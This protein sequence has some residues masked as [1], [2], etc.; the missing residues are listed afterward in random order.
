MGMSTYRNGLILR[1]PFS[2]KNRNSDGFNVK[3]HDFCLNK[4]LEGVKL[5]FSCLI[6]ELSETD[7]RVL[8]FSIDNASVE[9]LLSAI[10]S[11][12]VRIAFYIKSKKHLTSDIKE[13]CNSAI[14]EIKTCADFVIKLGL[15][16]QESPIIIHVGG[17]KGDRRNSMEKFCDIIENMLPD[18]IKYLAVIN[19]DKPSLFSVKDLLPGV[20]YRLRLPI[21]FR[22]MS[23]PTNQGNLTLN[24]SLFLAASTWKREHNPIFVY[25]PDKTPLKEGQKRPF[26]LELDIVFDNRLPEP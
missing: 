23:Y 19:D 3:F 21:V 25:L 5:G 1:F 2:P 17:A 10:E 6:F 7:F 14:E 18:Y 15:K 16:P 9:K 8:D 13:E 26:G 22:S 24:E 20:F 11:T 12:N 4:I